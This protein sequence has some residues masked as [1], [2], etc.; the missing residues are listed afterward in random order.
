M[1]RTKEIDWKVCAGL[2]T[3]IYRNLLNHKMSVQQ[4]INNSWLV[5]GHV[6][7][8]VIRCPKFYVSESG[9]QRVIMSGKKNVH[10][11]SY[12]QIAN[13]NS[14]ALPDSNLQEIY[15][16]PYS[17]SHFIWKESGLPIDNADLLVVIENK[18]YCTIDRQQNQLSL[19]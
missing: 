1:S 12:G 4:Q 10:A 16:D 13:P 9:R 19:F 3:R 18:V 2:P 11:Y 17:Q 6:T 15:Y 7:E 5:V 8:A 14:I